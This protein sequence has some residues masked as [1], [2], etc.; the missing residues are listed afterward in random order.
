MK[1]KLKDHLYNPERNMAFVYMYIGMMMGGLGVLWILK[2]HSFGFSLHWKELLVL[3]F[4]FILYYW[5]KS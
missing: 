3:L 2:S 5:Y 4:P 1:N